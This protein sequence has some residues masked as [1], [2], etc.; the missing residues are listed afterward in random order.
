MS[1]SQEKCKF[2]IGF[3]SVSLLAC[4]FADNFVSL[5]ICISFAS[6]RLIIVQGG[7]LVNIGDN[8]TKKE[9][10]SMPGI[11]NTNIF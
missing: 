3:S 8:D 10:H 5:Q 4:C 2:F 11:K 7:I 6:M 1:N 9:S